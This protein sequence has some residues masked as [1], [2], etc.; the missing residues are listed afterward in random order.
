M[1]NY[2]RSPVM[3]EIPGYQLFTTVNEGITEIAISGEVAENAI[4]KL[5]NEV[6]AIMKSTAA[7]NVVVDVR[8]VRG[9]FGFFEAYFRVRNYPPDRPIVNTAVVDLPE[10]QEFQSFH[11]TTA[12][13]AG[14]S[15]KCFTDI[16]AA[17]TWLKSM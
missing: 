1:M 9:R 4:E 13:N 5:Q 6:F 16:Q 14:L 10:N 8:S 12:R 3:E 7:R 11:E 2:L 15:F 17:R